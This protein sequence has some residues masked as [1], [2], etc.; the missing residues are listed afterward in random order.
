[1][2]TMVR[3][4]QYAR[5][6]LYALSV[7]SLFPTRLSPHP[8]LVRE[9]FAN[10]YLVQFWVNVSRNIGEARRNDFRRTIFRKPAWIGP[11]PGI[12][13][14]DVCRRQSAANVP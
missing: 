9:A 11:A 3:L 4:A 14:S 13:S 6:R 1:M 8:G 7:W 12:Q 5:R 10:T 2:A